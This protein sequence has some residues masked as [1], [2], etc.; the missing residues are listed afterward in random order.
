MSSPRLRITSALV[1][2]LALVVLGWLATSG[3]AGSGGAGPSAGS[4]A[5][6]STGPSAGSSTGP[7]SAGSAAGPSNAGPSNAGPNAG[8]TAAATSEPLDGSAAARPL[9]ALPPEAAQTWRLIRAGG[10][11]RYDQDGATFGNRERLLP[12]KPGGYYHE[13]TVPTPGSADRGARRLIT[14]S[15]GELYYT[16]DHYAS[17]VAVDPSG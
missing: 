8:L 3:P 2:L 9:S 11:F 4:N 17:F 12:S 14:G 15:G 13:Y 6:A 16:G 1:G 7:T 5:A 10:P